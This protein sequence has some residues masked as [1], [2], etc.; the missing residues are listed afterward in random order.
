MIPDT[1][2]ISYIG[3]TNYPTDGLAF[4]SA[5][6]ADPQ[7]AGTFASMEW[8]IAEITDSAS[9]GYDPL[10]KHKLEWNACWESG[11]LSNF[12]SQVNVPSAAVKSGNTYRARVRHKGRYRA[13]EPLVLS[14]FSLRPR[15][16]I[17]R[18]ITNDLVV[19]E[20]MYN[21]QRCEPRGTR[22]GV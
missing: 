15:C 21:P 6:F 5:A 18:P 22:G 11:E 3:T 8:R 12:V 4:E 9:P 17:S 20:L 13:L 1:P 7:G 19:S 16:P 14:R 2:T 10:A